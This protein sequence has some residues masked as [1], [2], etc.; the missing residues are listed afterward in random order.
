MGRNYRSVPLTQINCVSKWL[1]CRW[2][3]Y[4]PTSTEN[5]WS[6]W[7][8]LSCHWWR[9]RFLKR[10]FDDTGD[11]MTTLGFQ[12]GWNCGPVTP[13]GHIDLVNN[14]SVIW[15]LVA[16]RHQTTIWNKWTESSITSAHELSP[17]LLVFSHY[18]SK[19][20]QGPMSWMKNPFPLVVHMYYKGHTTNRSWHTIYR[21]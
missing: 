8:Q 4:I 20:T 5:L 2:G 11:I 19:I 14:G 13:C 16:S 17:Q 1:P 3:N 15:W 10:Q 9:R 12:C 18:T 21:I 6:S 7:C